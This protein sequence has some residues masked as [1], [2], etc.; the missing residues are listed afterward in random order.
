MVKKKTP[1]ALEIVGLAL[2]VC[3]A[4]YT[5]VLLGDAGV[6]FPLWH[7]AVLPILFVVSAASTGLD[8]YKRQLYAR[9]AALAA[10]AVGSIAG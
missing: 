6:A 10:D 3:V 2:S 9:A 5:G 1:K 8:V 4:S 7:M